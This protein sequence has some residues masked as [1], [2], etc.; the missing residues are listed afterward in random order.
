MNRIYWLIA[1]SLAWNVCQAQGVLSGVP[2][3]GETHR[4]DPF[5][6]RCAFKDPASTLLHCQ[7]GDV[8]NVPVESASAICNMREQIVPY[9]NEQGKSWVLCIAREQLRTEQGSP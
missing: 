7:G 3:T 8:I 1:F 4:A 5:P 6:K 9:Q 2:E